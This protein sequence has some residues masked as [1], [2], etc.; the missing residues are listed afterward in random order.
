MS[1]QGV[2]PLPLHVFLEAGN[3]I[4]LG[5]RSFNT[6]LKGKGPTSK[7]IIQRRDEHKSLVCRK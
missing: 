3:P 5:N 7:Q 6:Q 1:A 4:E 2:C